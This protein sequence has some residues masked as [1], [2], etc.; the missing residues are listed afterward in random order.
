MGPIQVKTV[1]QTSMYSK[2][3]RLVDTDI[4]IKIA[5]RIIA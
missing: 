4:R 5:D 2:A 3:N 1:Q